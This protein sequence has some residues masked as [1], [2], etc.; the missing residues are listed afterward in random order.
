MRRPGESQ[1]EWLAAVHRGR[2]PAALLGG[3]PDDDVADPTSDWAVD[4]DSM[5]AEVDD[6][7]LRLVDLLWPEGVD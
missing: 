5:A 2:N 3:S 7:M 4:H 6:L 1:A